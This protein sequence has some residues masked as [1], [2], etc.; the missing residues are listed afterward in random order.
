MESR[1][2]GE[3]TVFSTVEVCVTGAGVA[4]EIGV[5]TDVPNH[6]SMVTVFVEVDV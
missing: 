1:T 4:V 5:K 6:G 3:C 2:G